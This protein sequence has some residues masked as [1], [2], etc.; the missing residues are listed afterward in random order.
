VRFESEAYKQYQCSPS[1][2]FPGFTWCHKEQK[3]KE[4]R[5]EITLS[6]SILHTQEGTAWYVNSYIEPTFFVPNDVQ[7]EIDRLSAKFGEQARELRMPQREGLPNAVIAVWGKIQ[8]EPVNARDV[9][10]VASGGGQKGLLVSFLGDLRR[11]AKA[12]VPIYR[13]AG[14][15][16]FLWAAT[17]NHDGRGALRFLTIDASKIASPIVATNNP[18]LQPPPTSDLNDPHISTPVPVPASPPITP[19]APT[20][21]VT[22]AGPSDDPEKSPTQGQAATSKNAQADGPATSDELTCRIA[23]ADAAQLAAEQRMQQSK[24]NAG[25][26]SRQNSDERPTQSLSLVAILV[27]IILL[28]LAATYLFA[29]L[30]NSKKRTMPTTETATAILSDDEKVEGGKEPAE[31]PMEKTATVV[32]PMGSTSSDGT[33]QSA[34]EIVQRPPGLVS[35]ESISYEGKSLLAMTADNPFPEALSAN[36]DAAEIT[37]ATENSIA[38]DAKGEVANCS[39]LG[40]A[41]EVSSDNTIMEKVAKLAKL[42]AGGPSD[43]EFKA[44]RARVVLQASTSQKHASFSGEKLAPTGSAAS[45]RDEWLALE[46]HVRGRD[47]PATKVTSSHRSYADC[48]TATRE[49]DFREGQLLLVTS[50]LDINGSVLN[51]TIVQ[52]N[53]FL[54]IHGNLKGSLTIEPGANVI[55]EGSVD[56]KIIDRG[57]RLAINNRGIAEFVGVDGPPEAEAGGVLKINLSAIATNWDALSKRIEGECAAVVK[58]DAYGC[59]IDRVAATLAEA[60]CKTFFVS[61]LAEAKRVRAVAPK[62]TIYVLN[63]L[64][65]GTGPV[66]AEANARPVI[67]SLIEL[68][69]WD[70]FIA[71]SQWT[72]GFALNV[73]TGTSRLGISL[74]EATAIAGRVRSSSHGI[75]LLISHLDNAESPD[76]PLNDRQIRLL[77]DLRQLYGGVS[78]SLANSSGIFAGSKAHCDLVRA[79]TAL[80][81]VNPT[82]GVGNP[83]LPVIELRARI[84]QVCNLA[85]G[86]TIARN[87]GWIA[88]RHTRVVIVPVGYADGYPRSERGSGSAMQAI[89]GGRLCS[90]AGRASTDQLAIDVTDLPDPTVARRGEVVTL[91][92]GKIGVDD[93]AAAAK[94][95][96][97]EVL[98]NLGHR[99]HRIYYAS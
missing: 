98:S 64:Y 33:F 11:S 44:L 9:S 20:G 40:E 13:L 69:E 29:R 59:G 53:C 56:G 72:G 36:D 1:E 73:K 19:W 46:S 51:D 63:G 70:A 90:I 38:H 65:G 23:E 17:F 49:Y 75:T 93:L 94:M 84:V 60:G 77:Q 89:V 31:T 21:Q 27:T 43:E 54:H 68:A 34:D 52:R 35:Q 41:S 30:R 85:P 82:P 4:E 3:K 5:N 10:I 96:G 48:I 67:N 28:G 88:K 74:D 66:F 16:G 97:C 79:G 57:G 6:H 62:S 45:N 26:A 50:S 81:G 8:L 2:K 14:G 83:M 78:A 12:R 61:D 24:T 32:L 99:F 55:V 58:A 76:H 95:T 39:D 71:S 25:A 91:I 80:Y 86:E 92:G 22:P 87:T 37:V 18:P 7:N 15:A 42:Y 47:R